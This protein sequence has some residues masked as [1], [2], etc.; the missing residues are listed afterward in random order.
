MSS[1]FFSWKYILAQP[2]TALAASIFHVVV[3]F[4]IDI[5]L[6]LYCPSISFLLFCFL[7]S[8]LTY[9]CHYLPRV[10]PAL[11]SL[12]VFTSQFPFFWSVSFLN[13]P[14]L[15]IYVSCIPVV[16][17]HAILFSLTKIS[18]KTSC[19]LP[20]PSISFSFPLSQIYLPF[21]AFVSTIYHMPLPK[22]PQ[23]IT[24]IRPSS[25]G[26]DMSTLR[27]WTSLLL[28]PSCFPLWMYLFPLACFMCWAGKM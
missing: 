5:F 14:V 13:L 16:N 4:P 7:H 23:S 25:V 11:C 28:S 1:F 19:L 6:F 24:I 17:L 27:S 3:I 8:H 21:S 22:T 18:C 2:R 10:Y 12:L 15:H 26:E 20:S 9:Y